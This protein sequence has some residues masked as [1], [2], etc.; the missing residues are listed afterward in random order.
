MDEALFIAFPSLWLMVSLV[1]AL[2]LLGSRFTASPYELY[3][4]FIITLFIAKLFQG[5]FFAPIPSLGNFSK[6]SFRGG[7]TYLD[8]V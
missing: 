6:R 4:L 2:S 1:Y 5:Q 3:P 7:L 8:V